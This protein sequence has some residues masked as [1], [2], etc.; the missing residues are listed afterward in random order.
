[1]QLSIVSLIEV[2]ITS[3]RHYDS[4][5]TG[6]GGAHQL[7]K[8][9]LFLFINFRNNKMNIKQNSLSHVLVVVVV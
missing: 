2:N 8:L 5:L 6:F 7:T 9:N 3:L 1:M 4:F